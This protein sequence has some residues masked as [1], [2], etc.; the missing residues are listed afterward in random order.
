LVDCVAGRVYGGEFEIR[1]GLLLSLFRRTVYSVG[2]ASGVRM[3]CDHDA[4]CKRRDPSTVL[5]TQ[6]PVL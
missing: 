3:V 4:T 6:C 1:M 5:L 2:K